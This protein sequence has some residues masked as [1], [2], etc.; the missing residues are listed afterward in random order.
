MTLRLLCRSNIVFYIALGTL[1]AVGLLAL[2]A[3]GR[4]SPQNVLG[5]LI[6]LSNAFGLIAGGRPPCCVRHSDTCARY[7]EQRRRCGRSHGTTNRLEG[8]LA[9][10]WRCNPCRNPSAHASL[11]GC[12]KPDR[13]HLPHGVRPGRHPAHH[14]AGGGRAQPPAAALSPGWRAG[15]KGPA[16]SPRAHH[17][18]SCVILQWRS[19]S[20]SA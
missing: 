9:Y 3:T 10:H 4:V 7:V 14:V 13:R 5:L 12:H 1:G 17:G 18:A 20:L 6:A 8:P 15:Q 2:L 11:R 19:E 16:R